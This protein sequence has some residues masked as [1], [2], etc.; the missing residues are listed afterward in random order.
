QVQSA[1]DPP[2]KL[3]LGERAIQ[4]D[5]N[6]YNILELRDAGRPVQPVYAT[7]GTPIIVS[8]NGVFKAAPNP[9]AA[10]LVQAL[11]FS[12]EAQQLIIDF[13]G[14]RSAHPQ[15]REKPSRIPLKDIKTLKDDPTAV[16]AQGTAIKQRYTRIFRV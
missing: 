7:E 12:R 5:G 11:C 3:D 1:A 13:G 14:L 4:A 6:E 16:E 15:A 2:K 9:N 8:P 10:K